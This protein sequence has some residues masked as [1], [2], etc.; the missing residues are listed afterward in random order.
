MLSSSL[1]ILSQEFQK[2]RNCGV[3][4]ANVTGGCVEVAPVLEIK[5]TNKVG[6]EAL[7][8]SLILGRVG[9]GLVGEGIQPPCI[10][11]GVDVGMFTSKRIREIEE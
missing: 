11:M 3:A 2:R 5:F 8:P 10:R 4:Q 6:S 9:F 7:S 1:N